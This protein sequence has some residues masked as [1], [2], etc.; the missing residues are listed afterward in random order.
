[1][2]RHTHENTHNNIRSYCVTFLSI[3]LTL[4]IT[5]DSSTPCTYTCTNTHTQL[6]FPV[7]FDSVV[8]VW[9][10]LETSWSWE[11]CLPIRWQLCV[12]IALVCNLLLCLTEGD[13]LR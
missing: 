2:Q 10:S 7:C 8:G 12:T 3:H 11:S 5:G 4:E 1:M 6:C 9:G 13:F